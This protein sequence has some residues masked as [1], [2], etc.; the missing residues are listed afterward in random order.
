MTTNW[1]FKMTTSACAGLI[2]AVVA[3]W[4]NPENWGR[5]WDNWIPFLCLACVGWVMGFALAFFAQEIWDKTAHENYEK[6]IEKLTSSFK[7]F[8]KIMCEED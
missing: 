8:S 1:K 4:H 7:H 6:A 5:G 3:I 2:G